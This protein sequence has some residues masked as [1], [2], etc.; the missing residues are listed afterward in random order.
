[1]QSAGASLATLAGLVRTN[2][3]THT[4][5]VHTCTHA[6]IY[7]HTY[8][9]R[10]REGVSVCVCACVLVCETNHVP[11]A[12]AHSRK[13]EQA[14]DTVEYSALCLP[15]FFESYRASGCNLERGNNSPQDFT[16]HRVAYAL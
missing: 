14:K 1:M 6:H 5:T 2:T 15:K 10:E 3:H 11:Q 9:E 7:I 16:I 4:Y 8:R 13:S 12:H